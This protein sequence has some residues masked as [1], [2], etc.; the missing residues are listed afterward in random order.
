M[1]ICLQRIDQLALGY[2]VLKLLA[3]LIGVSLIGL[4]GKKSD[5]QLTL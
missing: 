3:F 5:A 2:K 1:T 4:N